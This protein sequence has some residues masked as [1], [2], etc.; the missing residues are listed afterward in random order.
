MVK[1]PF[2]MEKSE[3]FEADCGGQNEEILTSKSQVMLSID[4]DCW[5]RFGRG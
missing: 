1:L 2:F 3:L 5:F 4:V